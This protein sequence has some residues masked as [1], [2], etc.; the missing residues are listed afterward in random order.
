LDLLSLAVQMSLSDMLLCLW[1]KFWKS[2]VCIVERLDG[3]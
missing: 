2:N 3:E 1:H